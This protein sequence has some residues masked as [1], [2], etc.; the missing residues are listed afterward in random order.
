MSQ[1]RLKR[2]LD[3]LVRTLSRDRPLVLLLDDVR[4]ADAST[5]DLMAYLGTRCEQCRVLLVLSYR[6]SD[7]ALGKH[8]FGAVKLDLQARGLLREVA[9]GFLT[10]DDI[11]RYLDL[12]FPQHAFPDDLGDLIHARTEGSPLFMADLLRYLRDEGTLVPTSNEWHLE[13]TP[14]RH[15]LSPYTRRAPRRPEDESGREVP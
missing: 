13:G 9:L 8:A 11:G 4:W 7:L 6:P 12:A 5:V 3:A 2:E 10:R 14:P 15:P 1:E